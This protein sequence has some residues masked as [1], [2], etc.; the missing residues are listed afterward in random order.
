MRKTKPQ[1][2]L[3]S[4]LK[5]PEEVRKIF[6]YIRQGGPTNNLKGLRAMN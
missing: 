6:Y 5:I 4:L 1:G 3:F 2:I